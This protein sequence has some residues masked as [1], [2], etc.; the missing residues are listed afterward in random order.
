MGTNTICYL[1][2][3][4]HVS[5]ELLQRFIP[6]C[7]ATRRIEGVFEGRPLAYSLTGKRFVMVM[8]GNP[9]TATG[10]AFRIPDMLANRP[11]STTSATS[12]AGPGAPVNGPSRRATSRTRAA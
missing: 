1:D 2:D 11:T 8:A 10:A 3:I 6:L 7:D 9:Y 12:S 5:P 4:Q